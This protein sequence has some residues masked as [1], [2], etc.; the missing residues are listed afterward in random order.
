MSE[1]LQNQSTI[2]ESVIIALVEK[3][4]C[5]C[6]NLTLSRKKKP[7]RVRQQD[8]G[9]V[10][11][12]SVEAGYGCEIPVVVKRFQKKVKFALEKVTG[13]VIKEINVTVEGL[14]LDHIT[15]R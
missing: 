15:E 8:T 7:V 6:P 5:E 10:I 3:V 1:N 11:D 12:V 9:K 4:I 14:S 2:S 13:E